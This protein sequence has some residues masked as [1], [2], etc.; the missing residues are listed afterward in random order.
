MAVSKEIVRGCIVKSISTGFKGYVENLTYYMSGCVQATVQPATS[1]A[2]ADKL[3]Q[4]WGF[5]LEN[6]KFV[7]KGIADDLKPVV[8][9][10]LQL[11]ARYKDIVTG[12]VGILTFY[13][14]CQNGCVSAALQGPVNEKGV[15]PDAIYF[16]S[17]R[18]E[19]VDDGVIKHVAK[20]I[21]KTATDRTGGPRVRS[22]SVRN[23]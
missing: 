21:S 11:G 9:H 19:K 16:D 14:E 13:T 12:Y 7:G 10:D 3:E 17:K 2:K 4:G 1:G 20:T 15:V 5:D 18:M 8:S 6:L 22:G 23:L